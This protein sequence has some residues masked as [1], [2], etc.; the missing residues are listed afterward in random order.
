MLDATKA[1]NRGIADALAMQFTDL[2]F[3]LL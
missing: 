2:P 3:L 1:V